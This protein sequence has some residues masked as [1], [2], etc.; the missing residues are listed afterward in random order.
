MEIFLG[1]VGCIAF[2]FL[3]IGIQVL[4]ITLLSDA[5]NKCIRCPLRDDCFKTMLLGMHK[6]CENAQ[7][8]NTTK[9]K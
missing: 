4:V 7:P 3:L 5:D 6:L 1:I 2:A 9:S 8:L